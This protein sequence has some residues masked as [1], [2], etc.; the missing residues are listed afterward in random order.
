MEVYAY[1]GKNNLQKRIYFVKFSTK[2]LRDS[3]IQSKYFWIA[4]L[5]RTATIILYKLMLFSRRK[6]GRNMMTHEKHTNEN[7]KSTTF[8]KRDSIYSVSN[9]KPVVTIMSKKPRAGYYRSNL[10]FAASWI[11]ALLFWPRNAVTLPAITIQKS[12][13][14]YFN[15]FNP[16]FASLIA[17][18]VLKFQNISVT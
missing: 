8:L 12:V 4:A 14:C 13:C 9:G 6:T 15:M 3:N 10:I 18:G 11:T 1:C 17:D 5:L 7:N 16:W 2:S